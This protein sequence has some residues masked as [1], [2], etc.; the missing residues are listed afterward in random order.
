MRAAT[1]RVARWTLLGALLAA[2]GARASSSDAPGTLTAPAMHSIPAGSYLMGDAVGDGEASERPTHRVRLKAFQL[3]QYEVTRTEFGRFVAATGYR[4]DAER[5]KAPGCST[6]DLASGR[7]ALH[8]GYSWRDPGFEQSDA[9][10][11][12]CVSWNDAQAYIAWLNRQTHRHYRLPSEAEWE[13]AARAGSTAKYPWGADP[14]AGCTYANGQDQTPLPG[15]AWHWQQPMQCRDGYFYT[16][17]VGS[18]RSNGFDLHDTTGNVSEWVEDCYHPNYDGAPADGSV[19][20][21]VDCAQRVARGGSWSNGPAH[22]RV[23]GRGRLM[24]TERYVDIG[25]RLAR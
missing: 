18:Y 1:R 9:H 13:Y 25:F 23:S 8:A 6:V 14:N 21:S 12:V 10:P 24:P 11:V 2:I 3:G 16:A 17:P 15:A 19:W 20:R 5:D 7:W 4:T 22:L